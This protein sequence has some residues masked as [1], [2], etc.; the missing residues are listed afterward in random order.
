MCI[1][2]MWRELLLYLITLNDTH[3]HSHTLGLLWTSDQPVAETDNIYKSKTSMLPTVFEPTIPA[4]ERPQTPRLK[5]R[6]H[7]DRRR[8]DNKKN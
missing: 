1:D 7:W 8:A 4:S 5:P 3:T 2:C 6:G